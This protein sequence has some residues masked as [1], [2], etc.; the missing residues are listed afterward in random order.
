MAKKKVTRKVVSK[1][2]TTKPKEKSPQIERAIA[3]R[4]IENFCHSLRGIHTHLSGIYDNLAGLAD[5]STKLAGALLG[6][7]HLLK[8]ELL[9]LENTIFE[10]DGTYQ[11]EEAWQI[12]EHEEPAGAPER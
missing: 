7:K 1:Q 11:D 8:D 4:T 10:F 9:I 5:E 6:C 12:A 3:V 2:P